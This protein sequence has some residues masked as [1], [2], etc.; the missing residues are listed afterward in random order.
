MFA[1]PEDCA[2]ALPALNKFTRTG[3]AR[4]ACGHQVADSGEWK[5]SEKNPRGAIVFAGGPDVDA[6]VD[7][8][9]ELGA[10]REKIVSLAKSI[11]HGEKF[12][13]SIEVERE[14]PDQVQLALS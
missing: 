4:N 13:V 9:A 2:A 8:L 6:I 14:H 1:S 12:T 7:R 11:D 3:Q 10:D 5:Q